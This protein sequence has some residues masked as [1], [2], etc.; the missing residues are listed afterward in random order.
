MIVSLDQVLRRR[1]SLVAKIA[2]LQ[3]SPE[4]AIIAQLKLSTNGENRPMIPPASHAQKKVID[5]TR[6]AQRT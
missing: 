1:T 5:A 3:I 4:V 6:R 2:A